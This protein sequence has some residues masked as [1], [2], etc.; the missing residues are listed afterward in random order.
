MTAVGADA[1]GVP[2]DV[3][4]LLDVANGFR[5]VEFCDELRAQSGAMAALASHADRLA[6]LLRAPTRLVE[7][8][9]DPTHTVVVLADAV[10]VAG[11]RFSTHKGAAYAALG[12]L[13]NP[14]IALRDAFYDGMSRHP[15]ATLTMTS[16]Y[17]VGAA[18]LTSKSEADNARNIEAA[19]AVVEAAAAQQEARL[20]RKRTR[21]QFDAGS[22]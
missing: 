11:R 21:T 6:L 12:K 5:H 22:R 17:N 13:F 20:K 16:V 18:C 8:L 9:K 15:D 2:I 19:L 14:G 10:V 1:V 3:K 4:A 7:L